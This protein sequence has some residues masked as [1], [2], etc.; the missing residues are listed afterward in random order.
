MGST[1]KLTALID[2]V[3]ANLEHFTDEELNRLADMT[4]FELLDREADSNVSE[5]EYE[6]DLDDLG[7]ESDDGEIDD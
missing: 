5:D 1:T 6:D 4:S 2:Q 3:K 7:F